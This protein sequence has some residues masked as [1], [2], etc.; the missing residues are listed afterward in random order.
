MDAFTYCPFYRKLGSVQHPLYRAFFY[1]LMQHSFDTGIAELHGVE[2]AILIHHLAFWIKKNQ[3]NERHL[4]DGRVWTYNSAKA[5]QE[6]FPYWNTKKIY[7]VLATLEK[8]GV[9]KSGNYNQSL[10]DRTKW[11]TIIDNSIC[12]IYQLH[13]PN[14]ENGFSESVQPIPYSKPNTSTINKPP[15]EK[16]EE[17]PTMREFVDYAMSKDKTLDISAVRLKFEAW[18]AS[19]WRNGNGKQIKNWKSTLLNTIPYIKRNDKPK[20]QIPLL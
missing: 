17:K 18:E 7:R 5:M 10:Y 13:F 19:N 2:A 8:D 15:K 20:T 12:Q 9:L 3:A 11:Y 1:T 6:L 16:K 4:H 14:M